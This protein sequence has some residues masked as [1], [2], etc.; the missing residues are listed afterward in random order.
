MKS[1]RRRGGLVT[2]IL[3]PGERAPSIYSLG[4]WV[5]LRDGVD[6][7]EE[8]DNLPMLGFE[9]RF[10]CLASLNIP[11]FRPAFGKHWKLQLVC[12]PEEGRKGEWIVR[13][14]SRSIFIY[15]DFSFATR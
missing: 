5:D 11:L 4:G 9:L 3:N 8:A 1:Y 15:A 13:A 14:R 7:G 2:L 12:S 10:V 6:T